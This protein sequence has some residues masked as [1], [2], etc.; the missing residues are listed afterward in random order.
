M[1]NNT[2]AMLAIISLVISVGLVISYIDPAVCMGSQLETPESCSAAANQHIW[3]FLGFF[4]FGAITL[5]GGTI[6][7]RIQ[8]RNERKN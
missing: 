3:G 8:L 6:R 1:K 7:N 2:L 5:V 4:L